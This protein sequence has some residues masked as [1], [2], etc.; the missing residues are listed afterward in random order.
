MMLVTVTTCTRHLQSTRTVTDGVKRF[1][2][3]KRERHTLCVHVVVDMGITDKHRQLHCR[4]NRAA[5]IP[6]S[7]G[8]VA[9]RLISKVLTAY[10]Q[11]MT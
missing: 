5:P 8:K 9:G 2:V 11:D 10:H 7:Y 6:V 3:L 1:P 4:F